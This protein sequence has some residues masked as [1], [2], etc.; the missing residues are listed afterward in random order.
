MKHT[1][2]FFDIDG[3]LTSANVWWGLMD[4]YAG[5]DK[6]RLTHAAFLAVHYRQ[7]PQGFTNPRVWASDE[8][9]G[10]A[11]ASDLSGMR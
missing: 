7:D 4:D 1:V 11:Y 9:L 8:R 10:L 3:T 2:N 6:R 5:R